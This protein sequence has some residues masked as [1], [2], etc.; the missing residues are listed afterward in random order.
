MKWD[1][2]VGN[3][4]SLGFCGVPIPHFLVAWYWGAALHLDSVRN[5]SIFRINLSLCKLTCS[6]ILVTYTHTKLQIFFLVYF[7]VNDYAEVVT[8]RHKNRNN[9]QLWRFNISRPLV[10]S[11]W[12]LKPWVAVESWRKKD[13]IGL[14]VS[15]LSYHLSCPGSQKLLKNEKNSDLCLSMLVLESRKN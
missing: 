14:K 6:W 3:R 4:H 1:V 12:T 10:F 2:E 5:H 9:S 8:S 13:A 7:R 11:W 15:S